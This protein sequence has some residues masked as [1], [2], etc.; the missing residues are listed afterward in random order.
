MDN[1]NIITTEPIL[2][3]GGEDWKLQGNI[4]MQKLI[5]DK[6]SDD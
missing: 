5:K 3:G 2:I 6:E 1:D 4:F